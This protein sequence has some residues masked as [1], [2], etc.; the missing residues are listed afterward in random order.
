MLGAAAAAHAHGFRAGVVATLAT[1]AIWG[2]S[3]AVWDAADPDSATT[4]GSGLIA[5]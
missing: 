4:F 5:F 2:A 3:Y 1:A